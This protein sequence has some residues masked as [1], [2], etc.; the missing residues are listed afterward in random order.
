MHIPKLLESALQ[1]AWVYY[2]LFEIYSL[3]V[4]DCSSFATAETKESLLGTCKPAFLYSLLGTQ[5][6]KVEVL[7]SNSSYIALIKT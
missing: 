2:F 6:R 7:P 1:V 3:L 4:N 5:K